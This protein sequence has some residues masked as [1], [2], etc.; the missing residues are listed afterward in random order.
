MQKHSQR[1][2][3]KFV[4][5][6]RLHLY[7]CTKWIISAS[8]AKLGPRT[9]QKEEGEDTC[10]FRRGGCCTQTQRAVD[11]QEQVSNTVPMA[12]EPALE[13]AP[14]SANISINPMSQD[15]W[16][17]SFFRAVKVVVRPTIQTSQT[18]PLLLTHHPRPDLRPSAWRALY[19]K[20][21]WT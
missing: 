12:P 16:S 9:N 13:S 7:E 8:K 15:P 11:T 10:R 4:N 1:R 2:Y 6:K 19:N 20:E 3:N 18:P 14:A 17:L 21:K 5:R